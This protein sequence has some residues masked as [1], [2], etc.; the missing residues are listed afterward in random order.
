MKICQFLFRISRNQS[1]MP[2][3]CERIIFI[4]SL[5]E[6]KRLQCPFGVFRNR[7]FIHRRWFRICC[8]CSLIRLCHDGQFFDIFTEMHTRFS[9][10]HWS[11]V[12]FH[13]TLVWCYTK[14]INL[15][16]CPWKK[17]VYVDDQI[18]L[19][20][21]DFLTTCIKH[22]TITRVAL[23]KRIKNTI[24]GMYTTDNSHW[25]QVWPLMSMKLVKEE[26]G[27]R[28]KEYAPVRSWHVESNVLYALMNHAIFSNKD[29]NFLEI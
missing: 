10:D 9:F 13:N 24:N 1:K 19:R 26:R 7:F 2:A 27:E 28:M 20:K 3:K 29:W 12:N 18:L 21:F 16:H 22:F 4:W 8:C 23:T 14:N 6:G 17:N 11:S 25:K 15:F 5:E